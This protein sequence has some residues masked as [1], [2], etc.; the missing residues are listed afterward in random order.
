[1][2]TNTGGKQLRTEIGGEAGEVTGWLQMC[3]PW[4]TWEKGIECLVDGG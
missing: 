4:M 1:M 3:L 2:V